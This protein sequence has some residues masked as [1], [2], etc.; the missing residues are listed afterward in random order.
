MIDER[1]ILFDGLLPYTILQMVMG[2]TS[3]PLNSII[4]IITATDAIDTA[5]GKRQLQIFLS[6][7]L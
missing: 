3:F 4:I 5:S 2:F 6:A 1:A 7:I